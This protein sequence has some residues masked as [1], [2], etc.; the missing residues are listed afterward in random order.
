MAENS[1][2]EWTT[3]TFNPWIGCA[4]ALYETEDGT[5]RPHP[6]CFNCYA[7]AE[8]DGRRKRVTWGPQGTRSRTSDTYWKDPI[9]WDREA[10]EA[11]TRARVFCASL[12]DVFEDWK[13]PI[14][15]AKKQ[16]LFRCPKCDTIRQIL[17]CSQ[18]WG[19]TN[20]HTR[21]L[22][23]DDLRRDLFAL[24]EKTPHLDWLLLT[25]R[26]Q[27]L[28]RMWPCFKVEGH[29]SQNE[30]DGYA[31]RRFENVKVG[32]SVS[33][34]ASLDGAARYL[35]GVRDL[36]RHLFLSVE[37]LIAPVDLS[38]Y[39]GFVHWVI[40]GGE[41]EQVNHPARPFNLD[42]ARSIRDQCK[43]AGVPFFMK[44]RG[45][46]VACSVFDAPDYKTGRAFNHP[47]GGKSAAVEV[48][49]KRFFIDRDSI[50]VRCR[51]KGHNLEQLPEDLRIREFPQ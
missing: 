7:E 50:A 32:Y 1:N 31:F 12:A 41:S 42:W 45:T 19:A 47:D 46:T 17:K 30:G 34:Q 44:Q 38:K 2:I 33:D 13:G 9:R 24:I 6:G 37:P 51:N 49:G 3:H 39:L 28:R 11:G 15:D 5:K 26:P 48:H 14:I 10:K 22:T 27:N 23:M 4:H 21:P 18:C 29:V 16:Q 36:A 40:V 8:M 43:A 20:Q 35:R 25:K